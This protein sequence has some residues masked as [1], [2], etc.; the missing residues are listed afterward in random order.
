[1]NSRRCI[2][3]HASDALNLSVSDYALMVQ[4]GLFDHLVGA[5]LHR[6]IIGQLDVDLAQKAEATLG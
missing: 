6:E 1:M 4:A 5:G 2:A 3:G